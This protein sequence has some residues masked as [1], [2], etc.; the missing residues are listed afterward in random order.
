MCRR[1]PLVVGCG[2]GGY[3]RL[4]ENDAT[5]MR[6]R[7]SKKKPRRRKKTMTK[8]YIT[9]LPDID[10]KMLDGSGPYYAQPLSHRSY[11]KGRTADATFITKGFAGSCKAA[12]IIAAVGPLGPGSVFALDE[13]EWLL[14]KEAVETPRVQLQ[15]GRII[16]AGY[17]GVAGPQ[18]VPFGRAILDAKVEDPRKSDQV[19]PITE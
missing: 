5:H 12:A 13:D 15:D 1:A 3:C 14:L 11:I 7:A 2:L 6:A 17:D 16:D 18:I 10:V 8:R 19:N 4:V 9:L